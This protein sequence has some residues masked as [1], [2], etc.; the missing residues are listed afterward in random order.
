MPTLSKRSRTKDILKGTQAFPPEGIREPFKPIP[1]SWT[2]RFPF[3][4]DGENR[5]VP[6]DV[7]DPGQ[8]VL[9]QDYKINL[10]SLE[11]SW[12]YTGLSDPK[13]TP[14]EIL[15]LNNYKTLKGDAF[16]VRID[17]DELQS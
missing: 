10:G 2:T 8:A 3:G 6:A 16:L 4:V 1:V 5:S 12:G 11:L 17:E 7:L 13:G 15:N 14:L 9:I